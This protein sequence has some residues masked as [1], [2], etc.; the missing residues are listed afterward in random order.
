MPKGNGEILIIPYLKKLEV[1]QLDQQENEPYIFSLFHTSK[2][3]YRFRSSYSH[4]WQ[5]RFIN[6]ERDRWNI[7][8]S[9]ST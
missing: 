8:N 9:G 7:R 5:D 1:I 6:F 3:E 4:S 2:L